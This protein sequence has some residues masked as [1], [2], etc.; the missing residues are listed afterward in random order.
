MA[1]QIS[2]KKKY[3]LPVTKA[4]KNAM[5]KVLRSCRSQ[6]KADQANR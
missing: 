6:S 5:K 3:A 1:T 4:E 2:A